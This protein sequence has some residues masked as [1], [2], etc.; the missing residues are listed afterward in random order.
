MKAVARL[1]W[2]YFM[3][4]LMNR[5]FTIG[6]LVVISF[7]LYI[8]TTQPKAGDMVS[9]GIFGI[10]AFFFG[11]SLLPVMFGRLSRSH[12]IGVLP[13]GRLKLLVSVFVT[14]IVVSIP[15]AIL[16]PAVVVASNGARLTEAVRH[17]EHLTFILE[18]AGLTFTSAMLFTGWLY[19]A[20]W[21]M[22]NQRNMMGFAKALLVIVVIVFAPARDIRELSVSLAWNLQQIA[23]VWFV[24]GAGFLLWPR[25]N[26]VLARRSRRRFGG[27][28]SALTRGVT[29][30][31]F[32]LMLGTSNPWRWVAALAVPTVIATRF[33]SDGSAAWLYFLT[34][35][36]TVAGAIAG[37]AAGRSRA[38]W[39]RGDWSRE[40]LFAQVEQSFWWHNGCVLGVL[41][42]LMVAIG[43]YVEVSARTLAAGLPLLVLGT[44]LST[45]LGLLVTQG[46][47]WIECALGVLVMGALMVLAWVIAEDDA[48]LTA[49]FMLEAMLAALALVLRFA[50]RRR[51][52]RIDWMLS[53][54]NRALV[55]RGA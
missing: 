12:S 44:V 52:T 33:E 50:A 54:P 51:W 21:F 37:E 34:I 41:M 13:Y 24:F 4:T 48:E 45:Y 18:L 40:R 19:L 5:V 10:F 47:R 1:V 43:G 22:S 28:G 15:A 2:S 14:I 3:G 38:L 20:I 32:D 36:S 39:L 16:A 11:S 30:R 17:P 55:A 8:L 25:Y 9:P 27:T 23:V 29:G 35:F 42:L 26:A 6:G 7:S 49:V 53:R 31:E 46:L